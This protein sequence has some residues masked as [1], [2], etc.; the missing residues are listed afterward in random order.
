M[1]RVEETTPEST[2]GA[3]DAAAG[4]TSGTATDTA[5]GTATDM[6]LG[7]V[8]GAAAARGGRVAVTPRVWG[9][10]VQSVRDSLVVARRNLI[11]MMRIPEVVV[12]G[13]VQPIMFVV[14]F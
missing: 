8:S 4:T 14:L 5:S 10:P 3:T 6:A 12:F 13:L 1:A 7:A 9:G 11:R 2:S